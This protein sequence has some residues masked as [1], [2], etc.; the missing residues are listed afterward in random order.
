M[1]AVTIVAMDAQLEFE[2]DV[3]SEGRVLFDL[4]SRTIGLRETW[5]FGLQYFATKEYI[6]WLK[7][8]KRICDQDVLF[9]HKY[10]STPSSGGLRSSS[11]SSHYESHLCSSSTG[12][13]RLVPQMPFLFLAKFFPEDVA[14]GKQTFFCFQKQLIVIFIRFRADT[15]NYTAFVFLASQASHF[16][17]GHLLS[18]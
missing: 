18:T 11:S 8:D 12:H 3:R 7:L 13:D 2:I 9:S 10:L 4:I 14:E 1:M 6:A 5:Y 15:G 16:E 17:H